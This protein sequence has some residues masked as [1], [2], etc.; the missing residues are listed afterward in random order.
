M[1]AEPRAA[2]V[3]ARAAPR[4]NAYQSSRRVDRRRPPL[5]LR[6][7]GADRSPV[8]GHSAQVFPQLREANAAGVCKQHPGERHLGDDLRRTGLDPPST[9]AAKAAWKLP[10]VPVRW[11]PAPRRRLDRSGPRDGRTRRCLVERVLTPAELASPT[12]RPWRTCR[13]HRRGAAASGLRQGR[14]WPVG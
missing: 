9:A 14:C 2:P 5:L 13:P 1:T 8:V 11:A 6:L 12:N 3:G 7:S 10:N 4:S